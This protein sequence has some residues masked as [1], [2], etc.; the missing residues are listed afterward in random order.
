MED[1]IYGLMMALIAGFIVIA[2]ITL[3]IEDASARHPLAQ[4]STNFTFFNQTKATSDTIKQMVN[5]TQANQITAGDI[6]GIPFA[7]S[8]NALNAIKGVFAIISVGQ[9]I[10]TDLLNMTGLGLGWL[11]SWLTIAFSL[12]IMFFFISAILRWRA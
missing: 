1:S 2:G 3:F 8:L 4:N 9:S 5:T 12:A 6:F 7:I 11:A 10:L